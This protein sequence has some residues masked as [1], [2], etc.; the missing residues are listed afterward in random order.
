MKLVFSGATHE[1]TGSCTLL[2][3]GGKRL[4]IDCG[5]QQGRD[6]YE[7]DPLPVAAGEIDFILLTHAHIDHSGLAPL[8][9]KNGFSGRYH[10][11]EATC[12]LCEIMLRD[13]AHIQESD[14]EWKSRK[15]RRAGREADEP[16]FT[17][18]DAEAAIAQLSPHPYAE[19]FALADGIEV[20]FTDAGHLLG[21]SSIELW[22]TENGETRKLVFSGDIGNRH[23]PLIRDPQY[24]QNA[25]YVVMESTYGD[26]LHDPQPDYVA[27]LTA[28]LQRTFDRGGSVIIPAFAVGR[29]QELLYF[30]R[31]IK[32]Q[33]LVRG[34]DGFPVYVDSPLAVEATHVFNDSMACCLDEESRALVSRGVNP[35]MFPD[36]KLSVTLNESTAINNDMRPKVVLSASGMCEAGRIR[37]H[38]KHNLW[39]P[40][41][42]ILFVGYQAEN[43][44]GRLL[45]EGATS[46]K[47]FGEEIAVKAEV[48]MMS[49]I[50]GHADQKGLLA[51]VEAF[52]PKPRTVFLVHGE[53]EVMNTFAALLSE[54]G[55]HPELPFSGSQFD[56]IAGEYT[57]RTEAKPIVR[58]TET[59][60]VLRDSYKELASAAQAV[61]DIVARASG[62]T[63]RELRKMTR[64][65]RDLIHTWKK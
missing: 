53:N 14:F 39:R 31:Q 10:A 50:S 24:I 9:T 20:R 42:T 35:I 26:R 4:L 28:V 33:R 6:A 13:S 55:F 52:A 60:P 41:A 27:E 32:E 44:V 38:L 11:T 48:A 56:L 23:K 30:L 45:L 46:V 65:L 7:N 17:M 21:S 34:H 25:D 12:A 64:Q 29:T 19:R 62:Y 16:L 2:E 43:T 47:L 63:N 59:A 18:A 58:H 3:V 40:N 57:V 36:L 49:G 37:H 15:A 61:Q 54:R 5:M 22:L 8:M 1:V 51:W